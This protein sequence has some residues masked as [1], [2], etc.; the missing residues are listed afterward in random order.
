MKTPEEMAEEFFENWQPE[1][2]KYKRPKAR[3][4]ALEK[5]TECFL[6]GYQAAK[7]QFADADKVMN[8]PNNSNGWIHINERWPEPEILVL[9]YIP[10][11]AEWQQVRTTMRL[12]PV[13]KHNGLIPEFSTVPP[14]AVTH[15]QPLPK[16]P[17]DK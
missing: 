5:I 9:V 15:W 4:Y 3:Q 14:K 1:K 8:S 7:D 12:R 13:G 16:P 6:A 11:A 17:E 2:P 10:C